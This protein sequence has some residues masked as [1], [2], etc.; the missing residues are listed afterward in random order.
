MNK[1]ENFINK[2]NIKHNYKYD[3]SKVKYEHSEKKVCIICPEHG[4]FW[5]TPQAHVRG[6]GCV[7]CAN[8]KKTIDY[9]KYS[10]EDF[11]NKAKKVHEDKYDYSKTK[12]IN[13]K[14]KVCIICKEHGEFNM[15]PNHHL[16]GQG[17]PKCK[18]RN[19]EFQ[20]IINKANKI[21]NNKY[22]YSKVIYNKMH[23]KVTIICP[24]HGEFIQSL[25]K[26]ISK[27]QGCP[28]CAIESRA[29][30]QK[31]DSNIF[32]NKAKEIH[33]NKYDY[34]ISE[35]LG[36][37][38]YI[39]Y[40][41][42]KHGEIEQ[43]A[44][45]HIRGFGCAKCSNLESKSENEIFDIIKSSINDSEQGNRTILNGKELD[46]YIPNHN[47]AIEYN[48]L[49]WH[50]ELFR[51]D[52]NYHLNKTLECNNKN[53][54]LIQIFEDEYINHKDI[55]ISKIKH[56]LKLNYNLPKIYG[57]N[58]KIIKVNDSDAKRFTNYFNIQQYD[59]SSIIHLGAIYDNML[60]GMMSFSLKDKKRLKWQINSFSTNFNYRCIGVIG[61]IFKTFIK[62]YNPNEIITF[63]DIRWLKDKNN[64]I[65][66]KLNFCLVKQLKPDYEYVLNSIIRY[67]KDFNLNKDN[68][69]SKIW[70]CGYYKYKWIKKET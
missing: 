12:Y 19:L 10:T 15:L 6:Y 61:K 28:F 29:K 39:K 46:I 24:I 33:N 68:N 9:K 62:L 3:Y 20:D 34:S 30:K 4:E 32:F 26:H 43:R 37:N 57:R 41:C 47:L 49:R 7:K 21:H 36:M 14:T 55:V 53:I 60:I 63:A 45:D 50:S 1:Q 66:T 2:S 59:D 23:D 67:N 51:K 56:L 42:P 17:C 27:H 11:I 22:D 58:C 5:Q 65:Y 13:A 70:N 40:I 18:G 8:K 16:N 38:N 48:G 25:S 69:Y 64:N 54:G 44:C 31:M 52:K 35:Y